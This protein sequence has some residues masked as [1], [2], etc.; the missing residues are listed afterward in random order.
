MDLIHYSQRERSSYNASYYIASGLFVLSSL[1][2]GFFQVKT[3]LRLRRIE[4]R[5]DWDTTIITSKLHNALADLKTVFARQIT[6]DRI[7]NNLIKDIKRLDI[8]NV[9]IEGMLRNEPAKVSEAELKKMKWAIQMLVFNLQYGTPFVPEKVFLDEFMNKEKHTVRSYTEKYIYPEMIIT[10][11]D[12]YDIGMDYLYGTGRAW[13]K[14][15]E[16]GRQWLEKAA[17]KGHSSAKIHLRLMQINVPIQDPL[18]K[19]LERLA[20]T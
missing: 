10:E 17:A 9:R 11:N 12:M 13:E 19:R 8:Q 18:V 16:I 5:F 14:D 4:E 3:Y 7:L 2:L 1:I 6:R 20:L 15:T